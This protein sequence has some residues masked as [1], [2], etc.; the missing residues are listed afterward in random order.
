MWGTLEKREGNVGRDSSNLFSG[1]QLGL[2]QLWS[3][4]ASRMDSLPGLLDSGPKVGSKRVEL[5]QKRS[6][7]SNAKKCPSDPASWR[8]G[9]WPQLSLL[10]VGWNEFTTLHWACDRQDLSMVVS[11]SYFCTDTCELIPDWSKIKLICISPTLKC[12][13]MLFDI[14]FDNKGRTMLVRF[15]CTCG[16]LLRAVFSLEPLCQDVKDRKYLSGVTYSHTR[17]GLERAGANATKHFP[18]GS[19]FESNCHR[20][21]SLDSVLFD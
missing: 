21:H 7:G 12:T 19:R 18:S 13:L 4:T 16:L 9:H 10:Q 6:L 5:V 8:A 15:I 1:I 17:R 14:A 3:I 20:F 11:C 2:C